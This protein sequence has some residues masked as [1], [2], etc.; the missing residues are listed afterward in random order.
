MNQTID[1]KTLNTKYPGSEVHRQEMNRFS[2]L[3]RG[4][5]RLENGRIR[6]EA[7]QRDFLRRGKV[8]DPV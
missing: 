2:S 3:H 1:W 7:E 5:L 4:G 6:T 8:V